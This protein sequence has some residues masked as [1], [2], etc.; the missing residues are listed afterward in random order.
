INNTGT[1]A[2]QWDAYGLPQ[3]NPNS[4]SPTTQLVFHS[5]PEGA[6][7]SALFAISNVKSAAGATFLPDQPG[8]WRAIFWEVNRSRYFPGDILGITSTL[9]TLG[10]ATIA[11]GMNDENQ[12]VGTSSI[13]PSSSEDML[14]RAFLYDDGLIDLNTLLVSNPGWLLLGAQDINENGQIVGWG[15]NPQGERHA[16]L[17]TPVPEPGTMGLLLIGAAA[18]LRRG[19]RRIG[20]P[21]RDQGS[22]A[23][24]T[25]TRRRHAG[26]TITEVVVTA[27]ITT[28]TFTLL[29]PGIGMVRSS[30]AVT[31]CQSNAKFLCGAFLDYAV[32]HQNIGVPDERKPAYK[33]VN[34]NVVP[35]SDNSWAT[36]LISKLSDRKLS[37][38]GILE[39]G[40]YI[41]PDQLGRVICP[42]IPNAHRRQ[43]SLVSATGV[44]N[45]PTDYVI[46]TFGMNASIELAEEPARNVLVGEP[47]M[48]RGAV[49][50]MVMCIEPGTYG[51][52][53]DIEQHRVGSLSFGFVDGHAARVPIPDA[54]GP[55]MQDRAKI[56][57]GG[58]YPQL[59]LSLGSPVKSLATA[60]NNVMWWHRGN[61]RGTSSD[62]DLA[63][64][65][66]Q[67]VNNLTPQVPVQ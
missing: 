9:P 19:R 14:L 4:W 34:G 36:S 59:S 35:A 55:T 28:V 48:D 29:L 2:L 49:N 16:F 27:A 12:I 13:S 39:D 6:T 37:W 54:T 30:S 64:I 31:S 66:Y 40:Q 58:S 51:T 24:R 11:W 38:F 57:L 42:V 33:L 47:N 23:V 32:E 52:R 10:G 3:G 5:K 18:C 26:V 45:W 8:G 21:L 43:T 25:T 53:N 1:V 50:Y 15:I 7:T 20:G 41:T 46:N 61:V 63:T 65:V 44:Y 56:I 22:Y 67:P 62:R 17:L 60:Y